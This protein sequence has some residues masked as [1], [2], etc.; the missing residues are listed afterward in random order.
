MALDDQVVEKNMECHKKV[1][2][3]VKKNIII[4]QTKQ[5]EQYDKKH[6]NSEVFKPGSIVLKK[7]FSRKKRAGGK[8]DFC[9]VGPYK[10]LQALGRGLYRKV[11]MMQMLFQEYMVYI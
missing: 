2:E 6:A 11:F 9:W 10:I 8:M 5:K 7:V 1:L 4:A 3:S